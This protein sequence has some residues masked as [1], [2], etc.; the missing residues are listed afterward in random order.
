MR[1]VL[2]CLA[3]FVLLIIAAGFAVPHFAA[4]RFGAGAKK[5]LETSLG[6]PVEIRG[7]VEYNL[8]TGPGFTLNDV[9]IQDDPALSAEPILYAGAITAIPRIWPLF[10]GRLVFS[11]IRLEEARINLGRTAS[12]DEPA[13]WNVE[14]L[15]RPALFRAFPNISVVS[16]G[17]ADIAKSRI[18][19]KIGGVKAPFYILIDRLEVRP[20]SSEKGS[21]GIRMQGEPARTDRPQLGFGSFVADGQWTPADGLTDIT[22]RLERSEISDMI[23]LLNGHDAGIHGSVSGTARI[24]GRLAALKIN[25]RLDVS[26]IHGFDQLASTAQN[27]PLAIAGTWNLPGQ[28]FEL[29]ARLAGQPDSPVQAQFRVA[30]YLGAPHWGVGFTCHAMPL[31]PLLPLARQVGLAIPDGVQLNGTM[32]GAVS[33]SRTGPAE[34]S[35][36]MD[37]VS[38]AVSGAAPLEFA[39][40]R[41]IVADGFATLRPSQIRLTGSDEM[42]SGM[43][44]GD[45]DLNGHDLELTITSRGMDI[46]ALRRHAAVTQIPVLRDLQSG[47][48]KGQ[49]SYSYNPGAAPSTAGNWTGNLEVQR[50][51]LTLP[52]FATPVRV[53]SAHAELDGTVLMVRKIQA[54]SGDLAVTGDYRYEIGALRPHRFHLTAARVSGAQL[55]SLF[56][57]ALY[58]GGLVSRALGLKRSDVPDWL[59]QM[60]AEGT[61]DVGTL[62]LGGFDFDHLEF[63]RYLGR[64]TFETG[65][66][67]SALWGS[68]RD[69]GVGGSRSQRQCACVPCRRGRDG[70]G[71]E[72]RQGGCG[73]IGGD[74]RIGSGDLGESARGGVVSGARRGS[75]LSVDAGVFPVCLGW[76]G[77]AGEV[78][79]IAIVGW[80]N[81]VRGERVNRRQ[82]GTGAGPG[83]CRKAGA[84]DVAVAGMGYQVA[85]ALRCRFTARKCGQRDKESA[86]SGTGKTG[87]QVALGDGV[88]WSGWKATPRP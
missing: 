61:I 53:A 31:Q 67:Q 12:P 33:F 41:L 49:L 65:G 73:S 32:D 86:F 76:K 80:R 34:G 6:R 83:R 35:A 59:V 45:Y 60:R 19:F 79:R 51:T 52:L 46:G 71:V 36:W 84:A 50:A 74:F 14:P 38:L 66:S 13:R 20:P 63:S 58:R 16:G 44:S 57:P 81:H 7:G 23:S 29:S 9:L 21:W 40:V 62:D 64:C 15:T 26:G 27:W 24:T 54:R 5:A 4:G 28:L 3:G 47:V 48:W 25:G 69:R 11:S 42:N 1:R 82:W 37:H 18:N 75:G 88:A 70:P 2:W 17:V 77:A 22:V 72:G 43:I 55:E 68:R 87:D 10:A 39:D 8:F 85:S 56:R 30:D 78:E